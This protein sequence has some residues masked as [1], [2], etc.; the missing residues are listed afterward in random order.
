M[1]IHTSSN[2]KGDPQSVEQTSV[3]IYSHHSE[4]AHTDSSI[5]TNQSLKN[6]NTIYLIDAITSTKNNVYILTLNRTT[7]ITT[8]AISNYK[9]PPVHK[10]KYVNENIKFE[11]EARRSKIRSLGAQCKF[12][13]PQGS[14]CRLTTALEED[15]EGLVQQKLHWCWTPSLPPSLVTCTLTLSS[16]SLP[17][18]R[19]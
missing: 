18:T 6:N 17:N 19:K 7:E 14:P 16:F 11:K 13:K 1:W 4:I 5:M 10:G 8:Y 15:M 12:K 3:L 2:R 9:S